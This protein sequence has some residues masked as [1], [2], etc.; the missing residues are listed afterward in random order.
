VTEPS[1]DPRHRYHR[2]R[3]AKVI[4]ETHDA[5]SYVLD[6]P[7]PLREVFAYQ[8]GQFLTFRVP[9]EG[10]A[11]TRCYSLSSSPECDAEHKVTVKRIRDGRISN[12]FNDAVAAGDELEV[13]PPAG[14]FVLHPRSTPIVLLAGGSGITP[15]LSLAKT[16]LR[17]T[18]RPLALVYANRD[19]PSVIFARELESLAAAHPG[20][21]T[22]TH[23]LDDRD[24]FLTPPAVALHIGAPGDAD[25]YICGPG[26]FMDVVEA[27]LGGLGVARER[28]FIERFVSPPDPDAHPAVA[29]APSGGVV[30][31]S[32]RVRWQGVVHD[33]PY[34][35]G[36]T[37][38]QA[39]KRA[40]IDP[41][42]SCEEGYCSS[43]QAKLVCGRVS[44]P[45]HE[46]LTDADIAGGAILACQS[47]P[48]T[49][50]IEIDWD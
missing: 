43:C 45:Q 36:E 13:L 29:P 49:A 38:L 15:V 34:Q 17:T 30:P 26:P 6:V 9:F 32:F 3:V 48:L 5:R 18:D 7:A 47:Y 39:A 37:L 25:F 16:A 50:E 24:G 42:Y 14:H 31:T 23:S 12:W 20:R 19:L 22:I 28:I 46:A 2:L 10:K 1:D 44:M 27:A 41:P 40:G 8:A 33:V 11:L 35:A 21:F 4:D